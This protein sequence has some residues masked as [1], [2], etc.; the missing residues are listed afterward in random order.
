MTF[1]KG[2]IRL[3]RQHGATRSLALVFVWALI[4]G[5]GAIVAPGRVQ[6]AGNGVRQETINDPG[7]HLTAYSVTVPSN[8]RFDGAF[9]PGSPCVSVPFPVFRAHSPDGLTELRRLPRFDWTWSNSRYKQPGPSGCLAL[10]RE[11]SANEFLKYLAGIL[12]VS[13]VR[14]F[15]VPQ[16]MTDNLQRSL[17]QLNAQLAEGAAAID[18]TNASLPAMRR[19]GRTEPARQ[20]GS[21]A[22]AIAQYRNGSFTIEEQ[23]FVRMICTRAPLNSGLEPGA[24]TESCNASVRVIRAPKG[25]LDSAIALVE[26]KSLGAVENQEWVSKYMQQV[27]AAAKTRSD[28]ILRSGAEQRDRMKA[29]F[30]RAQA[31]RQQQNDQFI[32]ALQEKGQRALAQTQEAAARRDTVTAD[33]CDYVLDRQT[34]L[35]SGGFAKISNDYNYTWT[36]GWGNYYQTNY[37]NSDPNGVIKGDWTR[38]VQTHGDGTLK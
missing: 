25:Q 29:D 8:W 9:V 38:T 10:Q 19:M 31:I 24:F 6:A 11:L 2:A 23:L 7:L 26:G 1:Y 5:V 35:G 3:H 36:D 32:A 12:N 20:R 27:Q 22:A 15:P 21:L 18:R 13:L 17:D 34:V 4:A 28:A 16:A 33:W 30:D 14:D 37:V